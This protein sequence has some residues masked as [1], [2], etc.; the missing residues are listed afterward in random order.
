MNLTPSIS[1]SKRLAWYTVS[2][3]NSLIVDSLF[4]YT[5]RHWIRQATDIVCVSII[6]GNWMIM[7]RVTLSN[8]ERAIFDIR[9]YIANW[10]KR[11]SDEERVF[12]S[13]ER[14][15]L[16]KQE[17]LNV[18]AGRPRLYLPRISCRPA[19]DSTSDSGYQWYAGC[20][21]RVPGALATQPRRSSW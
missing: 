20:T 5:A 14:R 12:A 4:G 1:C 17:Q 11:T 18:P 7:C 15:G 8:I 9:S 13:R 19:A 10:T 6:P 3:V 2:G 16:I 21:V